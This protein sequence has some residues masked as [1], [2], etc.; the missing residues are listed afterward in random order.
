LA[1]ELEELEKEREDIDENIYEDVERI[2][3]KLSAIEEKVAKNR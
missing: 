3:K 1:Y 2:E